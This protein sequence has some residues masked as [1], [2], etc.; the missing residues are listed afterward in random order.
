MQSLHRSCPKSPQALHVTPTA[1]RNGGE[2]EAKHA[3]PRRRPRVVAG[4]PLGKRQAAGGRARKTRTGSAGPGGHSRPK[5]RA[6][7]SRAAM[8]VVPEFGCGGARG[9]ISARVGICLFSSL[10]VLSVNYRSIDLNGVRLSRKSRL[11]RWRARPL[12]GG[13]RFAK[14]LL[15]GNCWIIVFIASRLALDTRMQIISLLFGLLASCWL[16]DG[17]VMAS[18]VP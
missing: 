11:C 12:D 18:L 13:R 2:G 14:F 15:T 6:C 3:T 10:F 7:R 16:P 5:P 17:F 8:S 9:T 1:G 4:K